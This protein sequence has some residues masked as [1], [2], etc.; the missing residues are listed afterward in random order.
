LTSFV[1]ALLPLGVLGRFRLAGVI[2]TWWTDTLPDFKTLLENGFSGVIDGWVDA[3]GDAV[4]DDEAV[5]PIFDPFRHKLVS[6]TMGDYL[7]RISQARADV[8]SLKGDKLAFEQSN[9][10]DA[11]DEEEIE[12]WNCAMELERQIRALKTAHRDALKELAKREKAALKARATDDDRRASQDLKDSLQPV[13]DALAILDARLDPHEQIKNNLARARARY[14]AL[15]KAFVDELS[16]RCDALTSEAKRALVLELFAEDA[17]GNLTEA[18]AEKRQMLAQVLEGLWNKY[19]VTLLML[20]EK[21]ATSDSQLNR[22]LRGLR[23]A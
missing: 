1:A 2:A 21:R 4:E 3:I 12:N 8:A 15:T 13:L 10:P 9:P 23:Y 19:H 17:Q 11:A 5:G 6:H 7:E 22:I 20:R 14:R 18:V 16:N